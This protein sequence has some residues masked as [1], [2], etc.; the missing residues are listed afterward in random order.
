[1]SYIARVP[2]G[3]YVYLYER[4]SYRDKT[5]G[6][7]KTRSAKPVGKLDPA[8]GQPIY[9]PEY[10]ERMKKAG[11]SV[12]AH[13]VD[14]NAPMFSINDIK[15]STVQGFGLTL[16]LRENAEKSGLMASLRAAL[17]RHCD[18]IFTLAS[19][20]VA[21]GEPFLH[22]QDWLETVEVAENVGAMS[23]SQISRVLWE[24][25]VGEREEFYHQWA[26][27]RS[28]QEYLALDITSTSSYSELIEDVEWGY[29]RD[30]EDL[31][32]VNLCFLMG[33]M[34]RL[35]IY[36]T[37]YYG[38]IKD[39][40]TLENTLSKFDKIVDE[41]PVLAVMDKGFFST[42]NITTML[43]RGTKFVISMPFTTKLAREMVDKNCDEIDRY[44][45]SVIIGNDSLRGVTSLE[46]WG[47][48][49]VWAH[50]FYNPVAAAASREKTIQRVRQMYE[51]AVA[52]PQ[53]YI[54]DKDFG[55]WLSIEKCGDHYAVNVR[56]EL[57]DDVKRY[58][59]WMVIL[60]N[61]TENC[62][63][64]IRIYRAKDIVEKGFMRLKNSLDLGRLRVH[65]GQAM[66]T[67][68]FIGFVALIMLSEIHNVMLEHNFYR[69]WTMKQF[70]RV[71][72]KRR[73][74]KI[75]DIRVESPLTKEQREICSAFGLLL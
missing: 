14:E 68:I 28:E 75:G 57:V 15:N 39:V 64:A 50:V 19:H 72:G 59:G 4:D 16:L 54:G 65:G 43:E 35:P 34:S 22:C 60:S 49:R 58:G 62:T 38:S 7:V 3:K 45:N 44:K 12:S 52:D 13:P 66:Q 61:H 6:K 41:K 69:K 21:E 70:L 36:Q 37:S 32:Q 25:S 46:K 9:K 10:L 5:D 42:K 71:I 63:D 53:K 29:N 73:V 56:E 17:P 23:S 8:T 24:V 30:G 40:S 18:E 1:M 55:K 51:L 20:L 67:K 48:Y 26:S 31:A 2:V 74:Q 11:T 27:K 33:E 47:K